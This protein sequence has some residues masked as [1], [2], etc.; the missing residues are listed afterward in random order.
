MLS[1]G[2]I[3]NP[4]AG[5]GGP[6]AQKGSDGDDAQRLAQDRGYASASHRRT[7]AAL[8]SAGEMLGHVRWTTWGANMGA[9]AL[10]GLVPRF[11]TLGGP[12]HERTDASDTAA[13]ARAM[14]ARGVD[15][16]VFA[17]G[18]GTARVLLEVLGAQD[19]TVPVIGIPTGVKMHSGV[20]AT[21][22]SAAG[23]LLAALVRGGL[24]SAVEAQVRDQ[25]EEALR[26]GG[27]SVRYFGEMWVPS[28]GGFL[29]HT[30]VSGRESEAL[31]VAEIVA[32][33]MER[34][35]GP[36]LLG[37]GGT[38][39]AIKEEL[40]MQPT[41]LGFDAW[42]SDTTLNDLDQQGIDA[43]CAGLAT[44][45]TLILSF[46]RGQG[47]LLGRG[48]QQLGPRVLLT[49]GRAGLWVVGTRTKLSSL[50]GR[51]LLIDVD[52]ERVQREF[53]GLLPIVAGYQ[54]YLWH[55]VSTGL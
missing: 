23:E 19:R 42:D 18:D 53:S 54:D 16:I 10:A 31:A 21:S 7:R 49:I 22:P 51:P 26:S 41:L 45:A 14:L 48:N 12:V 8:R 20:F 34:L 11:H 52:D 47:F 24:V 1:V 36:A 35:Q 39:A 30:K 55:R 9:R 37:P 32:D 5:I 4:V 17:G 40:G 44:P 38:C 13:A 15:L 6:A 27:M 50:E 2:L 29:Q 33:V 3:V 25:D 28:Q 46:T 43:W